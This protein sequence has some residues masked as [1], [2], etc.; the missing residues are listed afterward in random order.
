M[1]SLFLFIIEESVDLL[2]EAG[3][4][5]ERTLADLSPAVEATCKDEVKIEKFWQKQKSKNT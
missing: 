3:K 5:N 2:E 4:Q 1:K